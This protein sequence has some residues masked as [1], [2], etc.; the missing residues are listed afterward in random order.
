MAALDTPT[1]A[2]V[3]LVTTDSYV[4]GALVLAHS[5]RKSKTTKHIVCLTTGSISTDKRCALHPCTLQLSSPDFCCIHRTC[6][7][8]MASCG[9]CAWRAFLFVLFVCLFVVPRLV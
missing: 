3:T 8:L 2:F 4:L 7:I 6:L 1:H 5:L 9:L